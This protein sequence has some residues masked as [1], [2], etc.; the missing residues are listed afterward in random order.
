MHKA[1]AQAMAEDERL[2][3]VFIDIF[4]VRTEKEF[5]EKMATEVIRQT[6]TTFDNILST[7][8]KYAS[9]IIS[10]LSFGDAAEPSPRYGRKGKVSVIYGSNGKVWAKIDHRD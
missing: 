5:Y 10:G 9:A 1:A 8:K 7:V 2:K 6:E 3:V 4:N